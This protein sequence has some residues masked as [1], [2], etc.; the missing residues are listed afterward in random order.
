MITKTKK[1]INTAIDFLS[2]IFSLTVI[3]FAVFQNVWVA[4]NFVYF[5]NFLIVIATLFFIFCRDEAQEY[6]EKQNQKILFP[7]LNFIYHWIVILSF[8]SMGWLISSF[9]WF[10][11]YAA[12]ISFKNVKK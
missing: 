3:Y 8:I 5:L 9:L 2:K 12:V 11:F 10:T 6:I 4:Q 7:N 1:I